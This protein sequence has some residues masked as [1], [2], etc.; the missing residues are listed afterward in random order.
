MD[1]AREILGSNEHSIE[2]VAWM[3]GYD[4]VSAFSKV[5][6]RTTGL[7]PASYRNKFCVFV[8]NSRSNAEVG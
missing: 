4:D 5:F 3:V 8:P 1:Q 7:P 6:L 2:K